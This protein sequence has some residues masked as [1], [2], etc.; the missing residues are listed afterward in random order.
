MLIDS[1]ALGYRAHYSTGSLDSGIAFGFL[2]AILNLGEQYRSNRFVFCWDGGGSVRKKILP[3][4]KASRVDRTDEEKQKRKAIHTQFNV[5]RD[6]ILPACGFSN[7]PIQYGYEA[8]DIIAQLIISYPSQSFMIVSSDHDLFQLLQYHN[9]RGIQP[10]ATGSRCMTS[11]RFQA[12]HGVPARDWSTV[13]SI[14]GCPGDGVKGVPGV[15][16]KTAIKYMHGD[17]KS[18]RVFSTIVKSGRLIYQNYQLVRL[19]FPGGA[20]VELKEDKFHENVMLQTFEDLGF[21][22]FL[23]EKQA[24]RWRQFC[25]GWR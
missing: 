2:T 7:H 15:G 5:L 20:P 16:E 4:Y 9:C 17:L 25:R 12:A 23:S 22:S 1:H 24:A 8:D 6:D 11:G 13:L 19:P 21:N 14:A 18:N 3:S 10:L